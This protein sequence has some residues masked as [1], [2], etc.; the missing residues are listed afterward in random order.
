[1]A[2]DLGVRQEGAEPLCY[3]RRPR[4]AFLFQERTL[5]NPPAYWALNVRKVV[6]GTQE[7]R[8]GPG[9]LRGGREAMPHL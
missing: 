8:L 3:R 5:K 6:L 4:K 2:P 9:R 1:M 7:S